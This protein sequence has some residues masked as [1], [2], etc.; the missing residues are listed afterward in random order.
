MITALL[1]IRWIQ[2]NRA[3]SGLGLFRT[4]FLLI[5][6][7][8]AGFLVFQQAS[9]PSKAYYVVLITLFL[10]TSVHWRRKDKVFLKLTMEQPYGLFLI[11]YALLTLPVLTI[12]IIHFQWVPS[13]MLWPGLMLIART[14][15]NWKQPNINPWWQ[16]WIPSASFEWK[17]GFRKSYLFI[18]P[19]WVFGLST[20]FYIASVPLSLFILGLIPLGFYEK[21]EPYQMILLYEMSPQRFLVH[22]IKL[23]T[24]IFSLICL[25]LILAFL[26]FHPSFWYIPAIEY[27]VF[28]SLHV[29]FIVTKYAFYRP[30]SSS[31]AAQI[32][33]SI[34]AVSSIVAVFLP[35]V[36]AMTIRFYFKSIY[37]L[38]LYLDDYN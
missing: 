9:D 3:L 6:A 29:Y 12:L 7:G 27:L 14:H 18:V 28:T 37:N 20:S 19:L 34:G 35:L 10:I 16:K 22:K 15:L 31:P 1:K 4:V 26:V 30:N 38:K 17:A 13:V 23:Q 24:L 5:L 36:W 32:F 8:F 33:G 2:F 25:P 21:G 11:E